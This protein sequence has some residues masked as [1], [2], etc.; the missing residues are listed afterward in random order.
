MTARSR[1]A[2]SE[3]LR[4]DPQRDL[5]LGLIGGH[6][7]GRARSA[8][9]G[10]GEMQTHAPKPAR[11]AT[12]VAVAADIG[13]L[14]AAGGL[15]R[16]TALD[17]GGVEQQ[18]IVARA[19]TLRGEH[20]DQPLEHLGETR[21][22][23]VQCVLGGQEGKEMTE[24]PLGGAQEAPIGGD[25]HQYLRDAQGH[26]FRIAQ[27]TTCIVRAFGQEVV[28]GAVDTDAEQVE[29]GV[30]RCLLVDGVQDTADFDLLFIAPIATAGAVAS[31]I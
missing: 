17:R 26:H 12:R 1:N 29:V 18:E 10:T 11:V 5:S 14:R 20:P 30:H 28:G 24:L 2:A 15:E 21:A 3:C 4:Q 16:A 13:Q 23:L 8:V 31:I 19:G 25:P 7:R 6:Q 22:A 27:P 9:C